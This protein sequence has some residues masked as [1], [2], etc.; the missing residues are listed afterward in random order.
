MKQKVMASSHTAT[1]GQS[2]GGGHQ[3]DHEPHQ[4]SEEACGCGHEHHHEENACG[5][6]HSHHEHVHSDSGCSC[7][8]SHELELDLCSGTGCSHDHGAVKEK[9][10]VRRDIAEILLAAAIGIP[11]MLFVSHPIARAALM[12][13]AILVVG[14]Q[15]VW[16]GIR[17]IFKLDFNELALM[18]IAVIAACVIGEYFE[19]MLVTLLFR[20]GEMLEDAAVAHSKREVEA[21]TKI[22][23]DNANLLAAD[24]ST[25]VVSAQALVLG[26]RFL[27]KSGERIPVD[28]VIIKGRSSVDASSLTGESAPREVEENDELLSGMVNMGGVLVAEATATFDNSTASRIIRMVRESAAQKGNTEKMISRFARIYTPIV[29]VV[30]ALMAALP[31]LLGFGDFTMWL[32]RSLVFLVASCPCALVIATPLSYFAGI[33]ASSKNGVLVKGSKY[34]EVLAK[35]DRIVMDK[36]GTLTTGKLSVTSVNGLNGT[37]SDE[38]LALAAACETFSNHPIA[39]AVVASASNLS[40]P[41]VEHCQEITSNGMKAQINGHEVLCGSFRLM[42]EAG[43]D[44]SACPEAA[45][46]VA[47]DG[48]PIGYIRIFDQPRDDAKTMMQELEA[49][50]VRDVVMLTGDSRASAQKTAEMIGITQVEAELLPQDK[51]SAFERI[52]ASAKGSVLFVGDGINDS[53]VI[54]RA[55]AG[56]AMGMGSDAAIESSDVVLLSN[57]LSS[58]PQAIRIARKT[59]R[60]ARFNIGFALAVKLAVFFLAFFGV[61]TMW[62]AV[63][64]DV[65]VT[66]LAVLNSTRALRFR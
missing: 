33:G 50:G 20:I 24:G 10:Q 34:M 54:A 5:H 1:A 3:H 22:I 57:R 31:P 2:C 62:M 41:V 43:V 14:R 29:I 11:T 28:A 23:P 64:A 36:T 21:I 32:S 4:H 6:D 7:G 48:A 12:V 39:R 9:S 65:G 26:D 15:I 60:L 8:Y 17:N 49:L 47:R 19:A 30:S 40:L 52:K 59:G 44:I 56:V 27:V 25:S 37:A 58:L 66:V 13:L 18:T 61:A 51:V 38:V 16:D 53:P 35:T 45:V 42:A 63:F 46:Y 55:D